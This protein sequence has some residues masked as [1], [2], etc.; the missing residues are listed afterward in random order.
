MPFS[1]RRGGS[2]M[3]M[4]H[5]LAYENYLRSFADWT[6]LFP[7]HETSGTVA[8][9]ESGNER[10]GVYGGVAL[11][12][13]IFL[14]GLPVGLWAS[15]DYCDIY[16][17]ALNTDVGAGTTKKTFMIWVKV[18]DVSVWTDAT[19]RRILSLR[20]DASNWL[21]VSRSST[22][23]QIDVN[24]IAGG[25]NRVRGIA[26]LSSVGWIQI[27]V[28]VDIDEDEM[29]VYA[30]G[31]Q[32]GATLTGLG[33]FAGNFDSTLCCIGAIATSGVGNFDG[34]LAYGGVAPVVLTPTQV[35]AS[36]DFLA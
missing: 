36:Y 15:G 30:Q 4:R 18:R 25:T 20:A 33:T 19:L 24:Y 6:M 23:N 14:D 21:V 2:L 11:D 34:Y 10:N 8:N 13:D 1:R 28:T 5:K 9:D 27:V 16:D 32:V 3:M 35:Q 17:A 12:Q 22:N 26:G 31:A 7:L 29:R